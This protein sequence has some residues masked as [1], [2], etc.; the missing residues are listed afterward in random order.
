MKKRSLIPM[1]L[2]GFLLGIH[3]GQIALWADGKSEPVEIFPYQ[4]RYLPEADYQAL[5]KGIHIKDGPEL[6]QLLEDFLS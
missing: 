2:V 4:A 6:Q 3:N 1:L 5:K